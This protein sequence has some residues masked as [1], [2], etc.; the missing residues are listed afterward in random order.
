MPKYRNSIK[1]FSK[2]L[3]E[4]EFKG[5]S[6]EVEVQNLLINLGYTFQANPVREYDWKHSNVKY[7][8]DI[9]L[10]NGLRIE[11][12]HIDG[13]VYLSWFKRDWLP[14]G[15]CIYVFKG[16]LKLSPAII[17]KYHPI[18]IHYSLLHVYLKYQLPLFR[19]ITSLSKLDSNFLEF[20]S[21][22]LEAIV[23]RITIKRI[24]TQRISIPR[25]LT[26]SMSEKGQVEL[27]SLQ[28]G[29]EFSGL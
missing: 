26:K 16:D 29:G 7:R 21:K 9:I 18:L 1:S 12:K 8:V 6:F 11:C 5:Y 28:A 13:R 15:N 25:I 17:E 23:S 14:K 4:R 24:L 20:V 19:T 2:V 3:T 27:N 22:F 10:T